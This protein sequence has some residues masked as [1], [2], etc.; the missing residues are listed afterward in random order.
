MK[1]P[2]TVAGAAPAIAASNPIEGE[3]K[4]INPELWQ[5]CAG[6]LVNLPAAGTHVV[7]FPQGHSEQVAASMKKDVDAQIPNYPNLPSKLL[8]L[9]HNVTLH[10]DPETDEV[11]AQM[12]LQPVPSD[13]NM[14]P[15]AQEIVT[16]DLH[17]NVWNF[18]HIYRGRFI[19]SQFWCIPW[20]S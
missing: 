17:D 14:Q 4:S 7:Y 3:K 12:T 10:A 9:L 15:P 5:A 16:R 2:A 1:L 13:F 18:R 19:C 11:Y 20:D 6:P 8:C